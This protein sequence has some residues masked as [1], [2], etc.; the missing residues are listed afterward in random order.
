[1]NENNFIHMTIPLLTIVLI[2]GVIPYYNADHKRP[3]LVARCN[4]SPFN[5]S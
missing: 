5:L 1:M 2:L 3:L 4:Y